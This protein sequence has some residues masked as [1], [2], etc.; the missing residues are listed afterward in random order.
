MGWGALLVLLFLAALS[1]GKL[2]SSW[3]MPRDAPN[4]AMLMASCT[5]S[6]DRTT[7]NGMVCGA[8]QA[9]LVVGC[10]NT[11]NAL[12][13]DAASGHWLAV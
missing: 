5:L 10:L 2:L 8:Q 3:K 11:H 12:G 13:C 6:A 1:H 9:S 4:Q 7:L